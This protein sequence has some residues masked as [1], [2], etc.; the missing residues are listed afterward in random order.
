MSSTN[1]L[2]FCHVLHWLNLTSMSLS[3]SPSLT[4]SPSLSLSHTIPASPDSPVPLP[5]PALGGDPADSSVCVSPGGELFSGGEVWN[6]DPCSQCT[7][8]RGQTLCESEACPPLLCQRPIRSHDSCC[9]HC[10]G[11]HLVVDHVLVW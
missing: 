9:P 5:T 2:L 7:C 6:M 8:R 3:S 1:V 4:P 11:K 10:P